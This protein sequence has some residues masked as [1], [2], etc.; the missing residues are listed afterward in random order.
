MRRPTLIAAS[1]LAL[2][3]LVPG[4]QHRD[5]HAHEATEQARDGHGHEASEFPSRAVTVHTAKSELFAEHP[6]LVVGREAPFAAHLT[7]LEDFTPVT[8]GRLEVVLTSSEGREEVFPIEGVLRPGIFRP[9]VTPKTPGEHRL[10]FR[11]T[12][13]KLSDV[14][15]AG[16]VT[17]F[18]DEASARQAAPEEAENPEEISF[19]KEQQWK[20]PFATQPVQRAVLEAGLT[21]QGTVKPASGREVAVVSPGAGRIAIGYGRLPKLGDTV[22][23]GEVLAAL[24][25]AVEGENDRA[26]LSQAVAEAEASLRQARRELAR[27]ER[28]VAEQAAPKKR[29]EEARTAVAIA[30]ASLKAARQRLAAK[31][32]TLSG[33]SGVSEESY[34]LK[35]PIA[36]TV[37]SAT[38]VPGAFVEAGAPLYQIVDLSRV[39]VEARVPEVE[40]NRVAGATRAEVTVP[41]AETVTVGGKHGGLV[42]VGGVL[43]PATRTAPAIFAVPNP[44]G[45]FRIGM[46]AEV[47]AL[48]GATPPAPVIPRSA[49]VDDNGRSIAYVQTGGESFERRVLT[50]GVKQGDRV[51]VTSGLRLGERVVTQGGYEIRLAT[52][53]DAVPDHGHAH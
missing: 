20:I 11:L 34:R 7:D 38:L 5:D 19:L 29:E 47:R 21:L 13:P 28:L 48:T 9:V 31:T 41:G 53:S 12:S 16:A 8:E 22:R 43:D 46:S 17:V 51:Q 52:L 33:T 32:A 24:T 42:T 10:S 30:E 4:C 25:P 45:R 3:V 27:A 50:L 26:S 44:D 14:I 49:V 36:G 18:S 6:F 37:V 39:W 1:V 40:L 23:A 35:A 2:L 15:E